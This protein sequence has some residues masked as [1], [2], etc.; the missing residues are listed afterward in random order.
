MG[1]AG[2]IWLLCASILFIA[3]MAVVI[4]TFKPVR[5]V[6]PED[7]IKIEGIIVDI[8]EAPGFDIVIT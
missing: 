5:N 1:K 4:Q 6:Q 2:K 3:F 8:K 7:V